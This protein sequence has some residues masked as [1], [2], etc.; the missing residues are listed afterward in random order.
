MSKE[1]EIINEYK[2]RDRIVRVVDKKGVFRAAALKNTKTVQEAQE[3]HALPALV[4]GLT[5]R[6]CSAASLYASFLKGEERVVME[7][8]G[9]GPVSKLFVEAL[10]VGEIRC[11]A[12]YAEDIE[13][14]HFENVSEIIGEGFFKVVRV[15]YNKTEPLTS[16]IPIQKGDVSTDLAFFFT[17]SEQIPT[18]VIL[19]VEVNDKGMIEHS[20]GIIVQALPGATQSDLLKVHE[21][22]SKVTSLTKYLKDEQLPTDILKD[23]LPFDFELVKSTQLDFFCRCSKDKFIDKLRA[24]DTEELKNMQEKGQR[25]LHCLFCNSK[26]FL[27]DDDFEQLIADSNAKKN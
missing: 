3:K 13:K 27:D 10:Q 11:Y 16:V 12:D 5:A 7:M 14:L 17:Q 18:A 1:R 22:L 9:S 26:Y 20:A 19:D 6:L 24:F 21:S 25:E 4:A 15:L 23:I 2:L 8:D